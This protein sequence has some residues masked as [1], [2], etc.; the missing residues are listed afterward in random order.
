MKKTSDLSVGRAG[1]NKTTRYPN[2]SDAGGSIDK[3]AVSIRC[4]VK[5]VTGGSAPSPPFVPQHLHSEPTN[6]LPETHGFLTSALSTSPPTMAHFIKTVSQLTRDELL[7]A[8]DNFDLS[9][10]GNVTTLRKRVKAHID[11]NE[12]YMNNPRYIGLFSRQQRARYAARTASPTPPSL[13][14]NR[15]W[16]P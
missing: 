14:W 8:A 3:L 9:Q 11:A 1:K 7:S 6:F 13:G 10:T 15:G 2:F 16:N 5:G 4:L 12:H